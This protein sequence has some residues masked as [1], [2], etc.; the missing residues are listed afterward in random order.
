MDVSRRRTVEW[1]KQTAR[2]GDDINIVIEY[3]DVAKYQA[4]ILFHFINLFDNQCYSDVE[5]LVVACGTKLP[6]LVGVFHLAGV[7]NGGSIM[8]QDTK[9][10]LCFNFSHVNLLIHKNTRKF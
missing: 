8:V 1:L 2:L 6:P 9:L 5:N 10:Y 7:S 4:F 3:A